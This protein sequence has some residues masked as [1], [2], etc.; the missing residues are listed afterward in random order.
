[1]A[2]V[3]IFAT[4]YERVL[5]NVQPLDWQNENGCWLFMGAL[6]KDGY[7]YISRRVPGLRTPRQR[8]CHIITWEEANGPLPEGMTLDHIDCVAK[9]CCNPDHVEL[10]T[11]AVNS[12]RRWRPRYAVQAR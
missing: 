3:K 4:L 10:V 9:A 5:S 1:M 2:F 6:D 12:E 7:G 11:R 8:R